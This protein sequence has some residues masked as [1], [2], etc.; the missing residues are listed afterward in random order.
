VKS[1]PTIAAIIFIA[2]MLTASYFASAQQ[3]TYDQP[4]RPQ[5]HFSPERNW[6]ND[7]N[8]LVF[9]HGEYNLFFQ[10]NP[11]GDTWGHMSWGHAVSRDLLHWRQLPLAIP[12][13]NGVMIFTGSVV[14]DRTDSSGLCKPAKECL[15]AV[16]TRTLAP[17]LASCTTVSPR[18][19]VSA[20]VH[21]SAAPG[22]RT[23]SSGIAAPQ[24]LSLS[25]PVRPTS[26][27][28][29]VLSKC[30]RLLNRQTSRSSGKSEAP[31]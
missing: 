21:V 18:F 14:I 12:E 5:V 26:I 29:A 22:W 20:G 31:H 25:P 4:Y 13:Q 28:E 15:V 27:R 6:T 8:G 23:C 1:I 2:S 7:P 9:F 17:G 3:Q 16:Y 11:F 30:L 24:E 10:Y 19:T